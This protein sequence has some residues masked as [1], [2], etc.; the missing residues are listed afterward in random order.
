MQ[1]KHLSLQYGILANL[2]NMFLIK[3]P[4]SDE[5]EAKADL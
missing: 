5:K 2:S 1:L 3:L 4:T